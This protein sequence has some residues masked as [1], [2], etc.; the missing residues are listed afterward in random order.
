M[1]ALILLGIA[2]ASPLFAQTG[3]I[4]YPSQGDDLLLKA[5][6]AAD[7]T[8]FASGYSWS[9][10]AFLMRLSA[11]GSI[12]WQ[13]SF[14]D[15]VGILRDHHIAMNGDLL[16]C[17][18][19]QGGGWVVRM[20]PSGAILWQE[21]LPWEY[22][23]GEKYRTH[24]FT[25]IHEAANGDLLLAGE[26]LL[27][28]EG[29]PLHLYYRLSSD[30][31][32]LWGYYADFG[33]LNEVLERPDGS[34]LFAGDLYFQRPF[35]M[36]ANANGVPAIEWELEPLG[37]SR[38]RMSLADD[39]GLFLVPG[40]WFC[41]SFYETYLCLDNWNP[42]VEPFQL[43]K[44]D[45]FGNVT[46]RRS[47]AS[48]STVSVDVL[49]LPGGG[50]LVLGQTV[51]PAGDL[52][53]RLLCVDADGALLWQ[54]D[55]GG[56]GD[57]RALSIAPRTGG[58]MIAGQSPSSDPTG[59][60]GLLLL[61]DGNGEMESCPSS[62]SSGAAVDLP[63]TSQ[64]LSAGAWVKQLDVEAT[65]VTPELPPRFS[66]PRCFDQPGLGPVFCDPSVPNS[67][68]LSA[69]ISA[70]GSAQVSQGSVTLRATRVPPGK[71]GYFVA[72]MGNGQ[73]IPPGSEGQLC[74]LG[75]SIHRYSSSVLQADAGGFFPLEIDPGQVPG[76][77]AIAPGETW[78]FQA[79]FRDHNPTPTSNFTDAVGVTFL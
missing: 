61:V 40:R 48:A 33:S 78:N 60:D 71:F 58:F 52:D 17:G 68:G 2:A 59:P 72:G 32:K 65:T 16:A 7:G 69:R 79:W 27:Q 54:R 63:P 43:T 34:L 30:G 21:E 31:V 23:G 6:E 51:T 24:S 46:W 76:H 14:P 41:D 3:S 26:S 18:H 10:G 28:P 55:Y 45:P 56:P 11:E 4:V 29:T 57:D 22:W 15:E 49:A 9:S 47:Y 13:V 35:F 20:D 44:L 64:L 25:A 8:L 38:P 39:G 62:F 66:E 1:R 19:H 74:L 70:S 53:V 37:G 67:T 5:T 42:A 77:G 50:A 75:S 36:I 12:L 73:A